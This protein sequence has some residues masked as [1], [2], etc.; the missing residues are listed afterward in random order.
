M[1]HARALLYLLIG[2]FQ[3]VGAAGALPPSS[4]VLTKEDWD[5]FAG[6]DSQE[7]GWIPRLWPPEKVKALHDW[8]WEYGTKEGGKYWDN[9]IDMLVFLG[10]EKAIDGYFKE[11]GTYALSWSRNP[12]VIP[13]L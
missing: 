4:D 7:Y 5:K 12:K 2:C 3:V 10:D 13:K 9:A 11:H 8:Y 1:K 6:I